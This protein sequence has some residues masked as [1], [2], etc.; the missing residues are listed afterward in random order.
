M[1]K[2]LKPI[3]EKLDNHNK[4][5]FPSPFYFTSFIYTIPLSFDVEEDPSY[6]LYRPSIRKTTLKQSGH[7]IGSYY[8]QERHR[9]SGD[10]SYPDS[11][12]EIL[13]D[14]EVHAGYEGYSEEARDTYSTDEREYDSD[15]EESSILDNIFFLKR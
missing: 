5:I 7:P 11:L 10:K 2:R 13:E 4:A 9:K 1:N 12:V 15:E 14:L 6:S 8:S 3:N